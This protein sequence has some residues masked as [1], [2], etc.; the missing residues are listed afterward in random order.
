[1]IRRRRTATRP[2]RRHSPAQPQRGAT[3]EL[4]D[5]RKIRTKPSSGSREVNFPLAGYAGPGFHTWPGSA[6]VLVGEYETGD[7]HPVPGQKD[8]RRGVRRRDRGQ[9]PTA[10]K[11]PNTK[12][13]RRRRSRH[14][15]WGRWPRFSHL[16]LRP[17]PSRHGSESASPHPVP[18][19]TG[20]RRR[21]RGQRPTATKN[22]DPKR[23]RREVYF[24]T[25]T[26]SLFCETFLGRCPGLSHG[27][28]LG[29]RS[30]SCG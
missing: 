14:C 30:L 28:P 9:R 3:R 21:D 7:S 29:L 23:L 6:D 19:K 11:N 27:A 2:T 5:F 15:S 26:W 18:C 25:R 22:P 12:Q 8:V 4:R 10:T 20:V 1:M 16:A 17:H 13:R 24:P